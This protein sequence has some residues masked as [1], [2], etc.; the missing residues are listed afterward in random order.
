[1][2]RFADEL[3]GSVGEWCLIKNEGERQAVIVAVHDDGLKAT[4]QFVDDSSTR[5]V[6]F[7]DIE[8]EG[9]EDGA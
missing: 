7:T 2:V 1:M 9:D 6:W 5:I 3:M 8:I 4:V